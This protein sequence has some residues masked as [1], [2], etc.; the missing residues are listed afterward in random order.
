M[1]VPAGAPSKPLPSGSRRL[2]ALLQGGLPPG[3]AALVYG[4]PFLG[5][6]MLARRFVA[7]NLKAGTPALVVVTNQT[8]SDL[9]DDLVRM[10]AAVTAADRKGLLRFVDTYSRAVGA[11]PDVAPEGTEY[12]D[13]ALDLNGIALAVNKAQRGIIGEHDSHAFVLDSVSTLV[14][15]SNPQTAFRFLQTL[16]GRIRRVGGTGLFLMDHGMHSEADVQMFKHIMT[17]T[18]ELREIAGK[19]QLQVQGL[20][21]LAGQAWVE[22]R[23][24]ETDF[25]VTGS[26]AAGRIR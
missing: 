21:A 12:L 26:F 18:I 24:S 2:D 11:A 17:G 19:P 9:R 8:S 5:K 22:Y 16:I 15:Y 23:F 20:G 4:P 1:S 13:G 14:A 6:E 25:E 3:T 10:D 7:Q